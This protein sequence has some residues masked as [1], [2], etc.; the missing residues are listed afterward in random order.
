SEIN[1][2]K[3]FQLVVVY[4]PTCSLSQISIVVE[5]SILYN[6]YIYHS[7]I[8]K[9]FHEHCKQLAEYISSI[10]L[11]GKIGFCVDIAS[12][13]G[14]L[15]TKFKNLS[16]KVLGIEPAKNLAKL[17]ISTGIDTYNDFWNKKTAEK[18]LQSY[19]HADIITSTN[20]FAHVDNLHEFLEGINILLSEDGAFIIEVPYMSELIKKNE[21]DTIYHE[22]LSY[23]LI[24]TLKI[25]FEKHN[26]KILDI[27]KLPIHGGTIRVITVKY[28]NNNLS[29]NK[30]GIDKFL[31]EEDNNG[32]YDIH[33]YKNLDIHAKK[34][35]S[36]ILSLITNIKR[37]NKRI[38]CYGAS[39]K[40][41]TLLNYCKINYRMIDYIIDDTP[42]KQNCFAPGSHIPICSLKKL[43]ESPPDYLLILAWNFAEEIMSKTKFYQNNGGKYIIPI[44]EVRLYEYSS[45]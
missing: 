1:N 35:K 19:S 41:I 39:A 26:L 8:S 30:K 13:D 24:K 16:H 44:P 15:L 29:I 28:S 14:C 12:N 32:M 38:S 6:H 10:I 3:Y 22:H 5:H 7:S 23:F 34:I 21:F 42:Q 45:K 40:G 9:T 11:K 31:N 37:Q 4:C 33:T 36:E 25:L 20:V 17:S 2:E 27:Q 18:I 43:L